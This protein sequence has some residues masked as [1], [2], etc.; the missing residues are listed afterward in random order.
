MLRVQGSIACGVQLPAAFKVQLPA[1]FKGSRFNCLR[2]SIAYG[3]PASF[4][5]VT[6]QGFNV[7]GVQGFKCLKSFV[8][9]IYG[10]ELRIWYLEFG[11]CDL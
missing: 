8:F 4:L 10:L 3:V 7:W 9:M 2:R 5:A 6:V 1:A 11:I